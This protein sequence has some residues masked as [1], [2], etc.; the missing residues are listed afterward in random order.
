MVIGEI[1]RQ[2]PQLRILGGDIA[3]A[4]G[5]Q[6]HGAVVSLN[7]QPVAVPLAFER[8]LAGL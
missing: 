6:P 1:L 5:P 7:Q 4:A 3:P 2:C 8:P